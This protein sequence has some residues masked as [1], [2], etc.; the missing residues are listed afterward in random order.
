MSAKSGSRPEFLL[1]AAGMTLFVAGWMFWLA[2]QLS[3]VVTGRGWPDA[4]PTEVFAEWLREPGDPVLAW[5]GVVGPA[6]LVYL[7]FVPLMVLL[8]AGGVLVV[9]SE[10]EWR[11]RRGFRWGRLG[12]ASSDEVRRQ[13][14]RRALLRKIPTIR[15]ALAGRRRV[16][17]EDVGFCLGRDVRSWRRVYSSVADPLL[18]VAPPRQG[19]DAH[20]VAPF[21]IDAPGACIVLTTELET[22]TTTYAMRARR[23]RVMVF[24]PNDLTRW[25]DRIRMCLVRGSEN[26]N[27]ADDR[28][29]TMAKYAGYH[30]GRETKAGHDASHFS[31]TAAVVILRCYLHAAALHGRTITDV[32]R[33]TRDP[34]D[35][36]PLMLLRRAE[37]AG[38]A[39]P[40]WAAELAALLATNPE[41]RTAMWSTAAQCLR[42]LSEPSV[43][44]HFSP[45]PDESFDLEEFA[46]GRNTLY[47]LVKETGSNPVTPGVHLLMQSMWTQ[48]R[49]IGAK[50]PGG[51]VEPPVTVEIN[52]AI[53]AAP[54]GNLARFMAL[55]GRSSVALHV[56]LRSV[57]QAK[58]AYGDSVVRM[59]WDN[60]AV[61]VVAGGL[62]NV[63]D[64][65]DLSELI[66]NVRH[67]SAM[68]SAG[69]REVLSP[70]LTPEELRTMEFGT[71]IVIGRDVRPVEVR[72][73]PW[74]KRKDSAQIRAGRDRVDRLLL[75][76]AE[77]AGV[78]RR[79]TDYIA[80]AGRVPPVLRGR[81]SATVTDRGN[82]TRGR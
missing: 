76:Y 44:A 52:E 36:E 54:M 15:P 72:L 18:V 8:V 4:S 41:S 66:G 23:G 55:M 34:S 50:M 27:V 30:M 46:S 77:S 82:G 47:V 81:K 58:D 29:T 14:G 42:F 16:A 38:V 2:G 37:A 31:A 48:L 45:G 35:P 12:F 49:G 19:K 21:T 20:F 63:D 13:L 22:F 7:I 25:P 5:P 39:V 33:W 68:F 61:K 10:W 73:T 56:Y 43:L 1:V 60:A 9:R 26:P 78:D 70:V 57:S 51:R 79:I 3:A 75:R 40:G 74:W 24:D 67:P 80:S 59:M 65:E 28:A 6:W 11:R 32:M 53:Y 62:G 17:P 71:A 69:N 64:L